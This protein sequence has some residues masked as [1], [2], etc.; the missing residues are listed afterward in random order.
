MHP[1]PFF[2]ILLDNIILLD[3]VILTVLHK[4]TNCDAVKGVGGCRGIITLYYVLEVLD[5]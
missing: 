3:F 1:T 4:H 2:G 5:V